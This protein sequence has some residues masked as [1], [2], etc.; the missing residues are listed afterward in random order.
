MIK[1]GTILR[2]NK[3]NHSESIVTIVSQLREHLGKMTMKVS[4]GLHNNR[5]NTVR[6]RV[7][8]TVIVTQYLR[9]LRDAY[10]LAMY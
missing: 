9:K 8:L 5:R 2:Y 7:S 1:R 6:R 10:G 4:Y 3:Y